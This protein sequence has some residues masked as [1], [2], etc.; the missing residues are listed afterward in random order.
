MRRR[1]GVTG[2]THERLCWTQRRRRWSRLKVSPA[3]CA[4]GGLL[5]TFVW[6]LALAT[7]T[8]HINRG[9][10]L[11]DGL[12]RFLNRRTRLLLLLLRLLL[13]LLLL[14]RCCCAAFDATTAAA[15][16]AAAAVLAG[17]YMVC[18]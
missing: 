10:P 13:L 4:V 7:N 17:T 9:A 11:C 15:A 18:M 16:V 14:L 3:R 5:G 2:D 6:P 8:L 1:T 12:R